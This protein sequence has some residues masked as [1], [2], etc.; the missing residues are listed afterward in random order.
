MVVARQ[1]HFITFYTCF[2]IAY[3]GGR[4]RIRFP[5]VSLVLTRDCLCL[6]GRLCSAPDWVLSRSKVYPHSSDQRTECSPIFQ[7][8]RE[9]SIVKGEKTQVEVLSFSPLISYHPSLPGLLLLL[10]GGNL[11]QP[12]ADGGVRRSADLWRTRGH[13]RTH[14]RLGLKLNNGYLR[15]WP[16]CCQG[17]RVRLSGSRDCGCLYAVLTRCAY[18]PL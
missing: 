15:L 4:S 17:T 2:F 18:V 5:W 14:I 9:V 6:L 10:F 13:T 11:W 7:Q 16:F 1:G 8:I 3:V 12:P